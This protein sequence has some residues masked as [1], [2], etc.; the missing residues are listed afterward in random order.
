MNTTLLAIS[1]PFL[2]PG[3]VDE[4]NELLR[5]LVT[6]N[7][8]LPVTSSYKAPANAVR[9]NII[10]ST[11]LF[12]SIFAAFGA[13]LGKQ[14]LTYYTRVC[15]D[16][17]DKG[18]AE[19]WQAKIAGAE[20]WNLQLLIDVVL[21]S[22]LQAALGLFIIGTVDFFWNTHTLLGIWTCS[23]AALALV[24]FFG[25]I[26]LAIVYPECPF[27]SPFSRILWPRICRSISI[28]ASLPLWYRLQ[29]PL[30]SSER[31]LLLQRWPHFRAIRWEDFKVEAPEIPKS[32]DEST[33]E[34]IQ[35]TLATT[36]NPVD[37][38]S[39][40]LA[41]PSIMSRD[42]TK[43]LATECGLHVSHQFEETRCQLSPQSHG[44]SQPDTLASFSVASRAMLHFYLAGG[45]IQGGNWEKWWEDVLAS[46]WMEW[47]NLR[48]AEGT[49]L[50]F[51][52]LSRLPMI[53]VTLT[54]LSPT[55]PLVYLAASLLR[56]TENQVTAA[57]GVERDDAQRFVEMA[58]AALSGDV[59]IRIVIL[60]VTGLQRMIITADL[61]DWPGWVSPSLCLTT[62]PKHPSLSLED[63]RAFVWDLYTQSTCVSQ[64]Y[65]GVALTTNLDQ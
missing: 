58:T 11:S 49:Y 13:V 48:N 6:N 15:W 65:S 57:V 50:R 59:T 29:R 32:D 33:A 60:C 41:I 10:F 39:A 61:R 63:E 22:F 34:C 36:D 16:M 46:F 42:I 18:Q 47:P 27:Q 8:A 35:F 1:L 64:L 30:E 2:S 54:D 43:H 55:P 31:P 19:E 62:K 45:R 21:P 51:I 23:L 56:L 25:T 40:V 12:F 14:W 20:K 37:T 7:H 26:I 9:D 44:G 3:L 5:M 28:P 52:V 38:L 17:T 53:R 24:L 4:T